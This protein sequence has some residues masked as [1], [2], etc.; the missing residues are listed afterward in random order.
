MKTTAFIWFTYAQYHS[1]VFLILLPLVQDLPQ[2]IALHLFVC[3][4]LCLCHRSHPR[5]WLCLWA[6]NLDDT[7]N[8]VW[9]LHSLHMSHGHLAQFH[10]KDEKSS[11]L[12]SHLTFNELVER[13][14]SCFSITPLMTDH[15]LAKSDSHYL[16]FLLFFYPEKLSTPICEEESVWIFLYPCNAPRKCAQNLDVAIWQNPALHLCPSYTNRYLEIRIQLAGGNEI[17]SLQEEVLKGGKTDLIGD[18]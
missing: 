18:W 5:G 15:A 14:W 9:S 10:F 13:K 12:Q 16:P 1:L 11:P 7:L 4:P 8:K 3:Q 2:H 17:F 6:C